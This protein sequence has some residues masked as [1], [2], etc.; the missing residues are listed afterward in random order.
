MVAVFGY[1]FARWWRLAPWSTN[2]LM[3]GRD[4]T[5]ALAFACAM[6]VILGLVPFAALLGSLTYADLDAAAARTS[7]TT[8]QID[9]LVTSEPTLRSEDG[10]VFDHTEYYAT[11]AWEWPPGQRHSGEVRLP[12][13]AEQGATVSVRVDT[14]G[15]W[16]AE[17]SS[18]TSNVLLGIVAA[19]GFW[20]ACT[21]VVLT[22]LQATRYFD[23]RARMRQW[24]RDWLKFETERGRTKGDSA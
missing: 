12:D 17:P 9:A 2:P 15:R 4:R 11:V 22:C 21:V 5:A 13:E 3:R 19:V 24:D 14:E 16:V 10:A 23:R 20:V 1:D 8:Q 18:A 6:A 7:A